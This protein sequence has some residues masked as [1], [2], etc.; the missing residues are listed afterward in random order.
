MVVLIILSYLPIQGS[1][2]LVQGGTATTFQQ[3]SSTT[4]SHSSLSYLA[5][6]AKGKGI[7]SNIS[8]THQVF[9]HK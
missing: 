8:L 5:L 9:T 3:S 2:R 1:P 7:N 6:V 4:L